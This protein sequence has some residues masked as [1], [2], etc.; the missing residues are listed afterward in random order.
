MKIRWPSNR[1]SLSR[2][3]CFLFSVGLFLAFQAILFFKMYYQRLGAFGCF[4][5]CFYYIAGYFL[6]KGRTLYSEIFFHHQPLFAYLSYLLQTILNPASLYQLVLYHRLFVFLFSLIMDFFLILRFRRKGAAFVLF[7]ETTKYYF[8]GHFFL[9]GAI[10]V[11]P[12]VYLFGL[13]WEKMAKK[14]LSPLDFL[15]GGFFVWLIAFLRETFIPATIL[16][17]ALILWGK[18]S[19]RP[20]ILSLAIFTSFS[21]LTLS[22]APLKDHFFSVVTVNQ[23]PILDETQGAGL[24]GVGWLKIFFYPFYLLFGGKWNYLRLILVG[25]DLI[26]LAS[27]GA[28]ILTQKKYQKVGFVFLV[29]GL[30]SIRWV[31]PG[32]TFYEAFHLLSWYSLFLMALFSL[33]GTALKEK[34]SLFLQTSLVVGLIVLFG[35]TVFSRQ[36][37]LWET[38]DRQKEFD[39]HYAHPF[40]Y[41]QVVKTLAN[42]D[43]TLFIDLWHDAIYWQSGLDSAYPYSLYTPIMTNFEIYQQARTAMFQDSPPNF[44]YSD[45]PK[46]GPPSLFPKERVD[47]YTE[48]L[49]DNQPTC[50]F[51]KKSKLKEINPGQWEEVKKF[52]FHLPDGGGN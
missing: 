32:Q 51:V 38:V 11:Y 22:L 33:V 35:Y 3:T 14:T 46:K 26:F 21:L 44:Y 34:I 15:I 27:T 24:S 19:R 37:F 43:D 45:C 8:F 13:G 2:L 48:L 4:D 25:L 10:A 6:T 18:N 47:D 9:P 16:I 17:Y 29:L 12:L 31:T 7:Y 1:F 28:L 42:R 30:S 20:K 39:L 50:L 40:V 41:G 49:F 52:G 5:Q 36:S 23:V